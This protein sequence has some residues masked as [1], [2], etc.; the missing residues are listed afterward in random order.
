M[1]DSSLSMIFAIITD[2]VC[3]LA[4]F[5]GT[6]MGL[7][8]GSLP[9]L[10]ATMG[11]A[12]LIPVTFTFPQLYALAMMLGVYVGGIAGGAVPSVLLNIPGTPSAVVTTLDGYPMAQKGQAG[13]ALGWALTASFFGGFISWAILVTVAPQ[14]A[15]FA[16][17]FGPPEYATLALFGLMII[18]SVAGK[19]LLKG[20]ISGLIGVWL[21]VFGVDPINGN[22]RL[23]F[24]TVN[25]MSGIAIMPALIGFYAIP[26]ILIS[27]TEAAKSG[28]QGQKVDTT[29]FL[30][31]LID[32]WRAKINIIRS[33]I[34]GTLVGMIPATG[35][36]IAAFMAYDQAKRFSKKPEEFGKGSPEG[37]IAAESGNNGV[38]GGTL[39]PLLTLGIPGDAPTAVL[40]GGLMIHN[41]PPGP[42]LFVDHPEVIYGIFTTLLMAN[43]IMALIQIFGIRIFVKIL[44]VPVYFLAPMLMVLS[45]VG[46][47]ALR[48][49]FFDVTVMLGLGFFGYLML[50]G[51]FPMAPAVLGLVLG[52]MLEGEMRR[53]LILSQG[54]WSIFITRPICLVFLILA[55]AICIATVIKAKRTRKEDHITS[56]I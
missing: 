38:T 27:V 47:Y 14:I 28:M 25:L 18:A 10:T 24:G 13:Q 53:S 54:D 7:V 44:E 52:P 1:V 39:I 37:L 6:F 11:V 56:G 16:L 43:V 31:K 51:G 50:R 19:S 40:L 15:R 2:P 36:N 45:I 4:T 46:S 41:L 29:R 49:N 12:I 5:V 33:S 8:F 21:S 23:T 17:K 34:V 26:Q 20:V 3:I 48:N 42:G 9:G 30:P 55:V 22:L 35:G 32:V